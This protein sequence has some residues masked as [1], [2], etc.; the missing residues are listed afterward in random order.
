M[1]ADVVLT[2][3]NVRT[4]DAATPQ[5][6]A[7]AIQRGCIVAVGDDLDSALGRRVERCDLEGLTVVPGFIDAHIHFE[8]FA[9]TLGRAD[10]E[11]AGL[12]EA[13]ARVRDRASRTPE[14]QWIHGRGWLRDGYGLDGFPTAAQLD[15]VTPAHPVAVRAKSGHGLWVNTRTLQLAKIDAN[16]PDPPGGEIVRDRDREPTGILLEAA[17]GLVYEAMPGPD[18]AE[19]RAALTAAFEH[20][21]CAGLTGVHDMTGRRAFAAYQ[22]LLRA[23]RLG[24]LRTFP[25]RAALPAPSW[26]FHARAF[27]ITLTGRT[28]SPR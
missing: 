19:S 15:S 4:L 13:L 20:A 11:V 24:L 27:C 8:Q 16:T 3:A 21:W 9:L 14:G 22:E 28:S 12:D 23:G 25:V 17:M 7:V 26:G 5:A 10:L 1:Q 2:N 18:V 6:R